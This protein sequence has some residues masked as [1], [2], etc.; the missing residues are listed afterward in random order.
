VP[1]QF[2]DGS[3]IIPILQEMGSKTVTEGMAARRFGNVG[4]ADG[5]PDGVLQVAFGHMM[6]AFFSAP[7]VPAVPAA[8]RGNERE[9]MKKWDEGWL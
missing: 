1:E 4:N 3:D 8:L 7:R 9:R 5:V 2:L 6:A